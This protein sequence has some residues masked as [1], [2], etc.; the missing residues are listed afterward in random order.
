M[1]NNSK[2]IWFLIIDTTISMTYKKGKKKKTD[3]EKKCVL[4]S[5]RRKTNNGCKH[6]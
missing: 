2:Q 1:Q 6:N 3:T 4:N 5:L